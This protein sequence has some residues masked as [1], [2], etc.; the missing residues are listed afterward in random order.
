VTDSADHKR[1]AD[2]IESLTSKV[3]RHH[4]QMQEHLDFHEQVNMEELASNVGMLVDLLY[5]EPH[6]GPDG[7]TRDGGLQEIIK[8]SMNGGVRI[9]VP[10]GVIALMVAM[11]GALGVI[12]AALISGGP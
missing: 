8:Q 5:G 10:A 11:I 4:R 3:D 2:A 1:M 9:H 6:I 7:P 12:G